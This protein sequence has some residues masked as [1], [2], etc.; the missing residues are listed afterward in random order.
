MVKKL[1]RIGNSLGV[2]LDRPV[3]ELL[4]IDENTPLEITTDCDVM[5][6]RPVRGNKKSRVRESA[7][8]M[9]KAHAKTPAK[10]AQ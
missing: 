6:M 1:S 7:A 2:I 10:L 3:L 4:Q 5:V 9:V 8:K